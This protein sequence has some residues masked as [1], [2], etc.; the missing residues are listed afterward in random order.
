MLLM[1]VGNVA[2]IF[3]QVYIAKATSIYSFFPHLLHTVPFTSLPLLWAHVDIFM[4]IFICSCHRPNVQWGFCLC[5]SRWKSSNQSQCNL[6][7]KVKMSILLFGLPCW[8]LAVQNV[9]IH[10]ARVHK[11]PEDVL[12]CFDWEV[13]DIIFHV[14]LIMMTYMIHLSIIQ[15]NVCGWFTRI[16]LWPNHLSVWTTFLGFE[17]ILTSLTILLSCQTVAAKFELPL[18]Y[19]L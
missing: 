5:F 9:G 15:L 2:S 16:T 10:Y 13:A 12:P 4:F 6:K 14:H 19:D 7:S 1:I 11:I 17:F 3:T 8:S 18:W